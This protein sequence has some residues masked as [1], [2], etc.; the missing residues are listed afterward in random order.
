MAMTMTVRLSVEQASERIERAVCDGAWS[1]ELVDRHVSHGGQGACVC[2]MV[3]DQYYMRTGNHCALCVTVDNLRGV[4]TVY[5]CS[6]GTKQGLLSFLDWGAGEDFEGR[7]RD[8]L[9][10]AAR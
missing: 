8:A 2:T 9:A 1:A 4:T 7:V 6:A 5:A 3:F 10:D